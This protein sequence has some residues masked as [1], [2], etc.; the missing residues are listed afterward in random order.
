MGV[1]GRLCFTG[2]AFA[3][4]YNT[5][6]GAGSGG[7]RA[8]TLDLTDSQDQTAGQDLTATVTL[9]PPETEAAYTQGEL[10]SCT[11]TVNWY[12]NNSADRPDLYPS[13]SYTIT[14]TD[15]T[16]VESGTLNETTLT[17]LG[18][19]GWPIKQTTGGLAID[20][21]DTL[22]GPADSYGNNRSIMSTG[23]SRLRSFRATSWK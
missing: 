10:T 1:T 12:D 20:L 8:I 15:G 19:T 16:T 9:A 11:Q 14:G 4:D 5:L 6:F 17:R 22:Y 7:D 3:V 18:F 21:P 23:P 13:I 2:S